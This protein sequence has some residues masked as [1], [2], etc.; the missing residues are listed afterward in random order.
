MRRLILTR[1]LDP[2]RTRTRTRHHPKATCPATT[3][4]YATVCNKKYTR[5]GCACYFYVGDPAVKV[6][7]TCEER[8][9]DCYVSSMCYENC[10]PRPVDR[11]PLLIRC[12]D[13][14]FRARRRRYLRLIQRQWSW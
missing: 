4:I 12:A 1:T 14:F 6:Y 5:I 10:L 11:S 7:G 13:L 3:P 2:A 8:G 9:D